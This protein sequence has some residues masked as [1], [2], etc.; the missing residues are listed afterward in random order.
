MEALYL[1]LHPGSSSLTLAH[2]PDTQ[3]YISRYTK[4]K[5]ETDYLGSSTHYNY[6]EDGEPFVEVGIPE[7]P[8]QETLF[9]SVCLSF[10]TH[11]FAY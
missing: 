3:L 10:S 6:D 2:R 11:L 8:L 1:Q 7:A 5:A 4:C 9:L